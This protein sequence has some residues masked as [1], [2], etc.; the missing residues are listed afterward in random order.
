L[1]R[2]AQDFASGDKGGDSRA[3]PTYL[4]LLIFGFVY[5]CV[6]V[7]DALRSQNTIQIIG[8]VIMNLGILVYTGIQK[9]QIH[10]AVINLNK[11][12]FIDLGYWDEVIGYVIAVPC[13]V[14]LGTVLLA[15]I[16]WKLYGE[17][18]WKIC[19]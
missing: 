6:L 18:G 19:K 8:I 12:N 11:N 14:A 4:A 15:F 7:W 5:Q 1:V 2:A 10:D 9:E 13:V 3:I 17:F 16:A